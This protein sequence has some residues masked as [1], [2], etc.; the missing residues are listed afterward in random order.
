MPMHVIK[1]INNN[2]ALCI[3]SKGQELVAFGT[4]IG[5]P[6]TP[7]ELTDMSRISRTYYNVDSSMYGLLNEIPAEIFEISGKLTD[8]AKSR[9]ERKFNT[10]IV[11]S[12]AD[13][14]NFAIKR[15]QTGISM[16]FTFSYDVEYLYPVEAEL[17]NLALKL[18]R[19]NCRIYLPKSEGT[20]IA[21]HFI[22]AEQPGED[23]SEEDNFN[24]MVDSMTGVVERYFDIEINKSGFD[25]YRFCSHL[26]YFLKRLKENSQFDDQDIQLLEHIREK[27]PG[28]YQC[29]EK[30]IAHL[31]ENLAEKCNEQ[32]LLYL[33][34][35]V[36]RLC[37]SQME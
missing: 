13:H 26:R 22:N 32:E 19:E 37:N 10:N 15:I 16:R 34:I 12:L 11:F 24:Q 29:V 2:V 4:G 27:Y 31:P 23:V 1:K 18:I 28:A 7:Y 17:G 9:L 20:S 36:I 14:I 5:F 3:D 35:Y 30:M 6:D 25:Y 33:T 8:I 21:L